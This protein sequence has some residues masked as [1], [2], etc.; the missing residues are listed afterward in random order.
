[1]PVHNIHTSVSVAMINQ[2]RHWK[3]QPRNVKAFVREIQKKN[4]APRG[5]LTFMMYQVNIFNTI[6]NIIKYGQDCTRQIIFNARNF[7]NTKFL[8]FLTK[9]F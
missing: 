6:F 7:F 3:D 8:D 5:E 2:M 9:F 4:V 1:M